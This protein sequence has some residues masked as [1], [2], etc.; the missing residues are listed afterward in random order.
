[1]GG[2]AIAKVNNIIIG[3]SKPINLLLINKDI[4]KNILIDLFD[5]LNNLYYNKYKSYLW[6]SSPVNYLNGSSKY[7][8]S[9]DSFEHYKPILGDLDIMISNHDIDKLF[10]LLSEVENSYITKS[11][12]Y[13]GQGKDHRYGQINAVFYFKHLDFEFFPQIDFEPCEFEKNGLPTEFAK[14]SHSSSWEDI[15]KGFKGFHHKCLLTNIVRTLSEMK[16][17][18]VVTKRSKPSNISLSSSLKDSDP[19]TLKAF[20]VSRGLRDKYSFENFT[21]NGKRCIKR[22]DTDDSV[23]VTDP[24]HIYCTIFNKNRYD[25]RFESFVGLVELLKKYDTD[26]QQKIV[27]NVCEHCYGE[28]SQK[29]CGDDLKED[30][31]IKHKML[32]YLCD[33]FKLTYKKKWKKNMLEVD[34]TGFSEINSERCKYVG[35]GFWYCE[36]LV[37]GKCN[38]NCH[39][40]NRLTSDINFDDIINF[41]EKYQ[42]S[43]KHIQ[44]TGGEPTLYNRLKDLCHFIKSK[45]IKIGLSTNGS[46]DIEFYK[47][48]GV[49]MFSISLD[50]YDLSILKT[51]GYENPEI[52]IET[53]RELSKSY[54]VNI[55]LVVDSLNVD[56][57]N[58]IIKY[59]ISLG[60]SDIKLSI[61]TKD[62]VKPIFDIVEEVFERFPIL[63][64]RINRFIKNLNMRGIPEHVN[65]K[66]HLLKN[67]ISIVGDFHY[68]C[69]VYKR[70]CGDPIGLITDDVYNDRFKFFEKHTPKLD[71]ICKTY[72]MDFKCA[73]NKEME[74]NYYV[75]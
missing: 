56:R 47:S 15:Q 42:H 75:K 29:L 20:S 54:Y 57:I 41:I 8:F 10:Q 28:N 61:N 74:E 35:N 27:D 19:Q 24:K 2:Y 4:L 59:I 63:S 26:I 9:E 36:I 11:I 32:Q 23:F 6:V 69:L 7:F 1:M 13:L 60:V 31:L 18:V 38:F 45:N 16:D 34:N 52:I 55:G 49:D 33:Q 43:L 71:P 14:F 72:C 3:K 62:E 30:F 64:Y 21:Y 37:T 66:C 73:F 48:L 17:A 25:K 12:K 53:I 22:L 68:P 51:R 58:H 70:E 40:C 65:F 67:D 44:I 5:Q 39:Y 50:D 46:A